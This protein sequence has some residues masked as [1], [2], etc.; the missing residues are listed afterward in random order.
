[1]NRARALIPVLTAVALAAGC[2]YS[3]Q[4]LHRTDVRTVAVSIF[5]SKEFRRELE[6]ELTRQLVQ[7]IELRTPY[8]V[9][10]DP[11]RADTQLR[12]EI[13]DLRAPVVTED[14]DTD[15]P[16]DS[17][18]VI[19][20]WFEWKDLRTGEI[21]KRSDRI[22]GTATYAGAIGETQDSATVEAS[23]RLAERIVE[24]MEKDW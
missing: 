13:L 21:L 24:A 23:K 1:M 10:H 11:R 4:P 12:G 7:T 19:A 22:S 20:C 14:P 5:A 16:Q 8:K 2:G 3:T 6:F 9:V 18:I 15:V 17:E